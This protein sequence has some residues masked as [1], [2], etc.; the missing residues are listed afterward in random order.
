MQNICQIIDN[1]PGITDLR[2]RFYKKMIS[3]RYNQI[4][5]EPYLSLTNDKNLQNNINY[6]EDL[7]R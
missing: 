4:I 1:T 2:K 3:E 7:D 6:F 5:R